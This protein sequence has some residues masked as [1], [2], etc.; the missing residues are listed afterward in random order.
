MEI[1]IVIPFN[2]WWCNF[3]KNKFEINKSLFIHCS[4]YEVLLIHLKTASLAIY[5]SKSPGKYVEKGNISRRNSIIFC[6]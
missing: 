4:I 5:R 6:N 1:P 2:D 3:P